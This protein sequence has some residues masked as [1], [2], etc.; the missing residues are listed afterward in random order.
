MMKTKKQSLGNAPSRSDRTA[1]KTVGICAACLVWP[2][3]GMSCNRTPDNEADLVVEIHWSSVSAPKTAVIAVAVS[4]PLMSH[5]SD[6]DP[7]RPSSELTASQTVLDGVPYSVVVVHR[8]NGATEPEEKRKVLE[9]LVQQAKPGQERIR[10][11]VECGVTIDLT[12]ELGAYRVIDTAT[13]QESVNPRKLIPGRYVLE[14]RF[15]TAPP[16]S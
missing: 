10:M 15:V 11:V 13:Q 1:T 16:G 7:P 9:L 8:G 3:I 5:S 14:A 2:M 12:I 4:G 6:D